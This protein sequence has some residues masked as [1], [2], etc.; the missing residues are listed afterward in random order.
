MKNDSDDV[1]FSD[2]LSYM[3][4]KDRFNVYIEAVEALTSRKGK[5]KKENNVSIRTSVA[6]NLTLVLVIG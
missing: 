4:A 1:S 6:S 5:N 3:V 2:G